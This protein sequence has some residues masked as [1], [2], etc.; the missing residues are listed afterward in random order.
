MDW[1]G[2]FMKR[3]L[4]LG[5]TFAILLSVCACAGPGG[6]AANQAAVCIVSPQY[7]DGVAFNGSDAINKTQNMNRV[8]TDGFSAAQAFSY[9]TASP[10][11]SGSKVNS[12]YS[13]ISLYYALALAGTGADGQTKQEFMNLLGCSDTAQLSEDMNRLYNLLYSDNDI[14]KT[15][16]ANSLWLDKEYQGQPVEY[17][18]TFIKNAASMFYASLYTV[19]FASEDAGPAMAKWISEQTN[20]TLTPEFQPDPEQI[21]SILNTVY[22]KD[23]WIDR[24]DTAATAPDIFH[25]AGGTDVTFDFMKMV[26]GSHAFA[27]GDGFLR[28]EL[29][30]KSGA[31]MVFVLPDEGVS[32][33]SLVSDPARLKEVLEGGQITNGKVTWKIPKFSYDSEYDLEDILK[34]LGL[35]SAFTSDADFTGITDQA[36]CISSVK[37]QTHI[38]IDEDGV[39]A[40]A[41][42]LIEYAG[43]AI[44]VDEAEMIL[45]RPFLYAIYSASVPLVIEEGSD[46][47]NNQQGCLLFVGICG[48]PA[49]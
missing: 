43:A 13:P 6:N 37:Q 5:F 38:A 28:S 40:S 20:G 26:Y 24:F 39:E 29:T 21:M 14:T 16:I 30:L 15:K 46:A 36:A 47:V 45:D 49:A 41:F 31:K 17:K 42:T 19:D 12:C 35:S 11:L 1:E 44:P 34:T 3:F 27:R 48:N 4:V 2:L 32:V 25:T 18:D 23:E 33:E 22:F 8:S 10:I 7:P 9:N